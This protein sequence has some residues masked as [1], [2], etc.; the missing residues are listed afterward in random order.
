MIKLALILSLLGSH[1]FAGAWPSV[2]E[3]ERGLGLSRGAQ[4][5][6]VVPAQGRGWAAYYIGAQPIGNGYYNVRVRLQPQ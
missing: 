6:K 5:P 2:G 3:L 1:A 4:L